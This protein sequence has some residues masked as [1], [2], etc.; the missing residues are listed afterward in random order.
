M[1]TNGSQLS[2]CRA[3][4]RSPLPAAQF[5]CISFS[6]AILSDFHLL[7]L[8]HFLTV[9]VFV[10]LILFRLL[11]CSSGWPAVF[12]NTLLLCYCTLPD[13]NSEFSYPTS[14]MLP[15]G[16]DGSPGKQCSQDTLLVLQVRG[17]HDSLTSII[18]WT[19]ITAFPRC[20]VLQ[21]DFQ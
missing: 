13:S 20:D 11:A 5:C 6:H 18:I 8:F 17:H 12:W 19:V 14:I 15:S 10:N 1:W 3:R 16:T 2:A 9:F 7:H 21:L 4:L